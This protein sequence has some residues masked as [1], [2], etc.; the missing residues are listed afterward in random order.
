MLLLNIEK[1]REEAVRKFRIA[2]SPN[3][4]PA[5]NIHAIVK[6][7]HLKIFLAVRYKIFSIDSTDHEHSYVGI[8]II[9]YSD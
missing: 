6:K 1:K 8:V 5:I 9:S 2:S 7:L 4:I 3:R